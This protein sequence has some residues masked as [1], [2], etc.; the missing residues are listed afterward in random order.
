MTAGMADIL[1][2][3]RWQQPM[4]NAGMQALFKRSADCL[5]IHR[6]DW[7]CSLL[8]ADGCA[9]T[10]HF[11]APDAESVRLALRHAGSNPDS[12]WLGTVH[13]APGVAGDSLTEANVLVSRRFD[14]PAVLADIQ[15]IEDGASA[16]L[17]THRVRFIR[18]Y[19]SIDRRRMLC[20][21]QAPD[22]ESVRIAQREARMPVEKVWAF[23]RYGP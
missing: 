23:R 14:E 18:T 8:S 21:Y 17:E 9:L 16:C 4:T 1:V 6:V 11:V 20:L 2:E 3:R 19:F 12:A 15:A 13:D 7:Q 10:C 5:P 22:A